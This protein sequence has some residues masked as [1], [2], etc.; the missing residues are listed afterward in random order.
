MINNM[1]EVLRSLGL[2]KAVGAFLVAVAEGLGPVRELEKV[3]IREFLDRYG[4]WD[5]LRISFGGTR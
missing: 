4:M 3:E 5:A 2:S 1:P